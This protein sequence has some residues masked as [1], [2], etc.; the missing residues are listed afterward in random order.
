MLSNLQ[1]FLKYAFTFKVYEVKTVL[2][3]YL[4]LTS[5]I[6]C[7]GKLQHVK[8]ESFAVQR[9]RPIANTSQCSNK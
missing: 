1:S 2:L 8:F 9:R 7:Y 3:Y 5:G 4:T 6:V